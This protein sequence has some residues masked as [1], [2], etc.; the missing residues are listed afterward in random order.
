MKKY[1]IAF[2]FAALV[3]G[4][5]KEKSIAR[6]E[7]KIFPDKLAKMKVKWAKSKL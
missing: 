4:E 5:G 7:A 6:I 2:N 1:S 3:H